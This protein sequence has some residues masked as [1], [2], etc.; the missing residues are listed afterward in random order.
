[1][2]R[3]LN[4]L[5]DQEK[6]I[7]GRI[8]EVRTQLEKE[9]NLVFNHMLRDQRRRPR[10]DRQAALGLGSRPRERSRRCSSA[11]S[12]RG[13]RSC[14]PR[15]S[16][17]RKRREQEPQPPQQQQGNNGQQRPTLVPLIAELK[18]LK[19]MELDVKDRTE[20]VE[21]LLTALGGDAAGVAELALLERLAGRH[22]EV[23]KIFGQIKTRLETALGGGQGEPDQQGGD[24][25]KGERK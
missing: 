5:A 12:R 9:D 20:H 10:G 11:T 8:A 18:M 22:A 21:K 6:E 19:Q 4:G 14:W 24:P 2:R 25:K 7:S 15:S 1:M 13:R 16:G 17:R 23:S 3:T